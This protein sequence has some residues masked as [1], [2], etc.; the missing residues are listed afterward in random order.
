[1]KKVLR[2][3]SKHRTLSRTLITGLALI[4]LLAL[5]PAWFTWDAIAKKTHEEAATSFNAYSSAR[6]KQLREIIQISTR[7]LNVLA[8]TLPELETLNA[9]QFKKMFESLMQQMG[10]DSLCWRD[11]INYHDFRLPE[12]ENECD[13]F[14][15]FQ[16]ATL[17]SD[18]SP[19]F[20]LTQSAGDR[21]S[22]RTGYISKVVNL[23]ND[24]TR[25]TNSDVAEYFIFDFPKQQKLELYR[26]VDIGLSRASTNQQPD[27]PNKTMSTVL[28]LPD[29]NIVYQAI[30]L[31]KNSPM[32][33]LLG[34]TVW[35][36]TVFT[37]LALAT[38]KWKNQILDQEVNKRTEELS[39]FAYRASH[40]LKSPLTS[41]KQLSKFISSDIDSG[42][43]NRAIEDAT[44]I[45]SQATELENLVGEILDLSRADTAVDSNTPLDFE[46][47]IDS[48]LT[49]HTSLIEERS[50]NIK[51]S[52]GEN[53]PTFGSHIRLLQIL[54]NLISNAVKYIPPEKESPFVKIS[55]EHSSSELVLSVS[56]NGAGFGEK[57]YNEGRVKLFTRYHP[58]LA[59]G[60]GIGLSIVCKHVELLGGS[61][62][63]TSNTEG[64]TVEIKLPW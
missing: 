17:L 41:I 24:S 45:Q 32:P 25:N 49:R 34:T 55:I 53:L 35:F 62:E 31:K 2:F 29:L 16:T 60:S 8:S 3:R 13:H 63:F 57:F 26:F 54:D 30:S 50:T 1:M 36:A 48:I 39:Q 42:H 51:V 52:L 21:N 22:A 5:I 33:L 23:G 4:V 27:S 19:R 12:N 61:I 37:L 64:S 47:M 18:G 6:A 28:S 15:L 44:R 38:L 20:L 14:E 40:D 10:T 7:T 59:S 11:M 46:K 58:K 56:D 43:H 9:A